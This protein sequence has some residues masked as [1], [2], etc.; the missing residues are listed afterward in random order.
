MKDT[1]EYWKEMT[2]LLRAIARAKT[3]LAPVLLQNDF[4]NYDIVWNFY[5]DLTEIESKIMAER[6]P[7]LANKSFENLT[8]T[9]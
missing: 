6:S 8:F 5:R 9:P 2:C 1:P 3:D 4:P 7:A